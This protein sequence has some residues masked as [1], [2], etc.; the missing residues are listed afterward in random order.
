M[1][2]FKNAA[3]AVLIGMASFSGQASTVNACDVNAWTITG[4]IPS[5]FYSA[6]GLAPV[7]SISATSCAGVFA[8][9]DAQQ[10]TLKPAP[11]L[12]YL[13]DGLLNGEEGLLSPTQFISADKLLDIQ[14]PGSKVD[15]G[16]IMLGQLNGNSGELT[17]S[18]VDPVGT[19]PSFLISQ[20][21]KYTQTK[22]SDVGG[23]WLLSV[24]QDIVAKLNAAGL[25]QRSYFDHLAFSVKSGDNWAVYD[26]DFDAINANLAVKGL[27]GFDLATP[28]TIGGT[29]TTNTDFYNTSYK[30]QD[31]SHMSVWARDPIQQ[32]SVPV[33]GTVF[34]V[35]LGL[36][37]LG[38]GRKK[39]ATQ[40]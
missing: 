36:L 15:P 9:N 37:A 1:K 28:Y 19:S 35:G 11:N 8:G 20:V 13:N 25:F 21:L 2:S 4:A 12:G 30:G 40:A 24:D 27:Q 22:T 33:P 31:I 17:Y 38:Y 23:T 18:S 29:W 7:G 10:G 6:V 16:W 32:S 39:A 5:S 14:T 26:F 34:L 3:S